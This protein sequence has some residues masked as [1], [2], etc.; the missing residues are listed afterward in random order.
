MHCHRNSNIGN[1]RR[2]P[3]KFK[4]SILL[5]VLASLG[6]V[7][8]RDGYQ[9]NQKLT[10]NIQTPLGEKSGSAVSN[11]IVSYGPTLSGSIVQYAV[12]GEAVIV[13]LTPGKYLF[14]LLGQEEL[15]SWTWQDV[16]PI[17][18]DGD[19][20]PA[21]KM[22]ENMREKRDIPI[23]QYPLL[24]TFGDVTN[25]KTVKKV[26]PANLAATF[27]SGYYLK[28]ITLEITDERVTEGKVQ[29]VLGWLQDIWPN[30]LDGRRFETMESSNRVANSLS[31][32]SFSTEIH[33]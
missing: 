31:A 12:K 30:R 7:G 25:P 2:V 4:L 6:L 16:L 21:F 23:K 20:R 11:E 26:D 8:C 10:V 9:W 5:L 32:N 15:A 33:K 22:I 14:A 17:G 27:G 19:A 29:E 13:E 1:K 28:S 18:K 24:V 3:M